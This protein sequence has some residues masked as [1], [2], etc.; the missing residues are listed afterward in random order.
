LAHD[1]MTQS[2]RRAARDAGRDTS[3]M[4]RTAERN[5]ESL[6][7]LGMADALSG[8]WEAASRG[9]SV[10]RETAEARGLTFRVAM[11]GFSRIM[12]IGILAVGIWLFLSDILTLGAI[13]AARVMAGFGYTLIERAVRNW[14]GMREAREAYA[15]L[16][17]QLAPTR[18]LSPSVLSGLKKSTFVFDAVGYRYP[19][20][21]NRVF[22]RVS[23]ELE[24]G[25]MMLVTGGAGT[26]KT[27]I[28]RLATGLLAPRSGLV[29]FGEYP[30]SRLPAKLRAELIGYL[31]QHI[32]LFS[33][34]IRD[35]ISRLEDAP[36][37]QVVDLAKLVGVHDVIARLPAGYDTPVGPDVECPL[38]GSARKRIALARALFGRPRLLVLD[39]PW[40]N[41]DRP[42]Q[43]KVGATLR[44]LKDEGTSILVTQAVNSNRLARLA[45]RFMSLDE[46]GAEITSPERPAAKQAPSSLLRRVK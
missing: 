10:E 6:T 16:A 5:R 36:F 12:R 45:D 21:P 7:G 8:K 34:T 32:E 33:G 3:E 31:P 43:R 19:Y 26:G 4:I 13:F 14:R 35:N 41:L 17:G 28:S 2:S 22:R 44:A 11:Q 18:E 1:L 42:T 25:E 15:G 20:Q 24:P 9:R 39:E 40:A 38:S 30:V 23:F 37:D 46:N 29:R 27:T